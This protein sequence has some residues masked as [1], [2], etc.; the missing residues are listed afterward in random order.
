MASPSLTC[1]R[2]SARIPCEAT[3][4]LCGW[5][6]GGRRGAGGCRSASGSAGWCRW[7]GRCAARDPPRSDTPGTAEGGRRRRLARAA[8]GTRARQKEAAARGSVYIPGSG[9]Q[10]GSIFLLWWNSS[11]DRS[12]TRHGHLTGLFVLIWNPPTSGSWAGRVN[13]LCAPLPS[14]THICIAIFAGTFFP[15]VAIR[16][17]NCED[18]PISYGSGV[19]WCWPCGI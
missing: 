14:H 16:E 18:Q 17:E 11:M 13:M 19:S 10:G 3:P 2:S 15:K 7:A 4:V 6:A 1:G 12:K 5:S 8:V 9:K